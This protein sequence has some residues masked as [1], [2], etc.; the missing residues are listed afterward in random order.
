MF[1]LVAHVPHNMYSLAIRPVVGRIVPGGNMLKLTA[2]SL[3]ALAGIL[4]MGA[5]TIAAIH[6]IVQQAA[7]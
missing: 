3:A 6:V 4:G 7:R 1:Y 2:L 5:A